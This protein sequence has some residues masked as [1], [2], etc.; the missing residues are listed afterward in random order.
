MNEEYIAQMSEQ[1]EQ[2]CNE[3]SA[4]D[5]N[6]AFEF[7]CEYSSDFVGEFYKEMMIEKD[8]SFFLTDEIVQ[9][10]LKSTFEKWLYESFN[11][12]NA[13]NF[14]EIVKK[15]FVAGDVH[16]RIGVPSWLIM[17]GIRQI[18]R[19][20]FEFLAIDAATNALKVA[21]YIVQILAFASEIMCRAYEAKVEVHNDIKH[22]YRL[23]SAM[24]DVAVQKDKQRG[25]LLNWENELMFKV[26][27]NTLNIQHT[28]LSKSEFGLWFIHK[29]AYAFASTDQVEI[30]VDKIHKVDQMCEIINQ[31]L[32]PEQSIQLIHDIREK[33]RQILHL[34]E[35]LFQV[36]EYINSGNDSLTQLLNRRYLSTIV[37]REINLARK[38]QSP[39]TLLAIDA[40]YFK[41]INDRW[42]HDAGDKAL[43][44]LADVIVEHTRGSD[45]AFR[46]GG[47]EF[48]LLLV[49]TDIQQAEI[50]AER[51]RQRVAQSTV[52]S[53]AGANFNLTVSIGLAK[54]NGH[55]DYQRFLDAADTA[56]YAAKHQGR[57]NV[58]VA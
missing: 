38:N 52:S 46:V 25:S 14:D 55:P 43:Q 56:L 12:P 1:W 27:S 8:A 2:I 9:S 51:I 48:L 39:L 22:S 21:G 36:A 29:A 26:F 53:I 58:Y 32:D 35:Q 49:D 50:V 7:I 24:Q 40:D 44:M 41:K 18:E 5:L 45:Y 4:T 13:L 30:I 6:Y 11:V 42:G 33:N 23:F 20:V 10:R 31:Q 17:H 37:S 57:N 28:L 34:V 3:Y 19:K 16:A 47:E 54:Y 15:Q